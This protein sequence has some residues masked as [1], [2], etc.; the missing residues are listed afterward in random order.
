M[1][2]HIKLNLTALCDSMLLIHREILNEQNYNTILE[3]LQL[4]QESAIAI[5][6]YI[7]GEQNVEYRHMINTLEEY[8]EQIFNI[9]NCE[10]IGKENIDRVDKLVNVTKSNINAIS[11]TYHVVF[12]PYQAAM[13]DCMESVWKAFMQDDQWECVVM[14]LPYYVQN[15]K[16]KRW[17]YQ[18]EGGK[19][20]EGVNI[21]HF[22]NYSLEDK[23]PDLAFVHNPFDDN[24]Y[25]TK[26]HPDYFSKELKKYIDNLVYIPYYATTGWVEQDSCH[27]YGNMD[28]VVMQSEYAKSLHRGLP[29]Y[30]KMI[31]LGTPKFD[32][33]MEVCNG[34]GI[35]PEGWD[36]IINGKK[37]VMLNTTIGTF[38]TF[39]QKLFNKLEKFFEYSKTNSEVVIIWR[40]HPLLEETIISM[41]PELLERYYELKKFFEEERIGILDTTPNIENTIAI[42]DVYVGDGGSSVMNLFGIA[43]K[44]V[45]LFD[46]N[47]EK[48]C[49]K[50]EQQ[51][52][53]IYQMCNVNEDKIV[54]SNY[55]S[56]VF[57]LDNGLETVEY[58]TKL[59]NTYTDTQGYLFM[60]VVNN[61]VYYSPLISN[62]YVKYNH[63]N[64]QAKVIASIKD[65]SLGCLEAVRYKNRIFYLPSDNGAIVICD[66]ASDRLT[67]YEDCIAKWKISATKQVVMDYNCAYQE[68]NIIWLCAEYT[69]KILKFNM[70][71]MSYEFVKVGEANTSYTAICKKGDY[72]WLAEYSTGNIVKYSLKNKNVRK[73]GIPE[74]VKTWPDYRGRG[75]AFGRMFPF[76]DRIIVTPLFSNRMISINTITNEVETFLPE[77]FG[78]EYLEISNGYDLNYYEMLNF[79]MKYEDDTLLIQFAKDRKLYKINMDDCT[80][81]ATIPMLTEDSYN[82]LLADMQGDMMGFSKKSTKHSFCKRESRFFTISEFLDD[83]TSGRLDFIKAKQIATMKT[84]AANSD[85]TCGRKIY[86]YMIREVFKINK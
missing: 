5:G 80:Y 18:Y 42:S 10:T 63:S 22:S 73:F 23:Q 71:D 82:R 47:L 78:D 33:V 50:I 49:T 74:D 77:I 86:E 62:S 4:C 58:I 37:T 83:L 64:K 19:F 13:W 56:G 7:E 76:G 11:T 29:N 21:V 61:K 40:P 27:L 32:R 15:T 79:A 9:S 65:E 30:E 70:E 85:G 67:Y 24:N 53:S 36:S 54:S 28:Y 35:V 34:G 16:E 14:P 72:I 81:T 38:L 1:R 2:K 84:I 57:R 66:I 17:E 20:E 75:V 60:A 48:D 55:Y 44:P 3:H 6:D 25:V 46:Y 45:F 68:D 12:L 26:I 31:P 52:F 8:C 39:G 43:G 69:N 59:D 51:E 41:K